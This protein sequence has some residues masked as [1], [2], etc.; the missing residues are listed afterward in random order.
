[1]LQLQGKVAIV[2]GASA[3]IG[4]ATASVLAQR[5]ATVVMTATQA[6]N[7]EPGAAGIRGQGGMAEAMALDL[8]EEASIVALV[9]AVV[10]R[11]GRIDIL[12][13]NAAD[14]SVTRRDGDIERMDAEVWDRVFRVNVRGTMLMCKYV[15][16]HMVRQKSGS[17]INTAS[18]L[19][20]QGAVVQAAY[21]ASKA[22]EI[23]MCRS[24]AASHGKR[25]VRCNAIV[26]GLI[27]TRAATDNLPPP[28]FAI[29]ESENL[30]PYLGQPEDIANAVAFL[31]S[32]DARYITG[33]ALV[34]D[35]GS[36]SH[37][38][39]FAQMNALGPPPD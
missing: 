12:H 31:A 9:E 14:L 39:G 26:P 34:A 22:A 35:G 36:S 16:P 8:A 37:I 6:A 18:A 32:D 23:Q 3:G 13:N 17:I 24:I 2:T 19:G 15:L 1:M 30:T 27:L 10:R 21:A 25:G 33:Q 20:L 29:Q 38:A 4:L 11:H 28:L 7:A 5:G